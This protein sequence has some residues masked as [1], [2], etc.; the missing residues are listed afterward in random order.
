MH[1]LE[2]ENNLTVKERKQGAMREKKMFWKKA[3]AAG[4]AAVMAAGMAFPAFSAETADAEE[5]VQRFTS[6]KTN[7]CG[8]CPQRASPGIIMDV[9][10]IITARWA[11][12][13][14]TAQSLILMRL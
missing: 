8:M 1:A 4:M 12:P 2:T 14:Q 6:T 10:L 3:A 9:W 13:R 7:I 5:S 11:E